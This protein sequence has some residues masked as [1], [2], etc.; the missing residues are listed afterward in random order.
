MKKKKITFTNTKSP[1]HISA[2]HIFFLLHVD[3]DQ[4]HFNGAD[5]HTHTHTYTQTQILGSQSI[6]NN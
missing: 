4:T 3:Q 6:G 1:I 5:E 2:V